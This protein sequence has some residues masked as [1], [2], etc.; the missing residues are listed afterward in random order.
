[1]RRF[2]EFT[3]DVN[4]PGARTLRRHN[5]HHAEIGEERHSGPRRGHTRDHSM[6]IYI[7]RNHPPNDRLSAPDDF[8][9]RGG[10]HGTRLLLVQCR[11]LE[12][13]SATRFHI[14][15]IQLS[16]TFYQRARRERSSCL[17]AHLVRGRT[18]PSWRTLPAL[19]CRS[20]KWAS[21]SRKTRR[22]IAL[23]VLRAAAHHQPSASI[24]RAADM[25]RSATAVKSASE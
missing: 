20:R 23:P 9:A 13:H 1:M 15:A 11:D 14:C 7:T 17:R 8:R 12:S 4:Q 3:S 21:I 24:A 25:N 5:A 16:S 2:R 22:L 19:P 18:R 10:R 6:S